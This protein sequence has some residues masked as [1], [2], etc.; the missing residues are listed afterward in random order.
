MNK[1]D[2]WFVQRML[3]G[4]LFFT[5]AMIFWSWAAPAQEACDAACISRKAQDPLADVRAIMTDNTISFGTSDDETSYAFQVQPVYSIPTKR[6]VNVIAR[7]VVPILGVAGGANIPRLGPDA[8]SGSGTKWGLGDIILQSFITPQTNADIK[9]GLGPQ[10]S[11]RTRTSDQVGGPGWGAGFGA[12]VFGSA[13]SLAYGAL[14]SH[15]WGQ[16]DFS[17]TSMQPIAFYNIAAF[18]GSYLGYSNS[19]TY[20][21]NAESG[22]RW[23]VPLGLTFGKTF[24]LGGGYALDASVGGYG[25]AVKPSGGADWQFKF[26]MSLFFP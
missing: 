2:R 10:V 9:W 16:N 6:G 7:A 20:N 18:G 24:V 1:L 12:V 4:M 17:L 19:V 23:Q 15:H 8:T 21:W 13:G 22:D 3:T 26:G 14:A 25:M 5:I 11:L